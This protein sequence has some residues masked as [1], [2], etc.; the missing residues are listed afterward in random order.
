MV[1]M[2]EQMEQRTGQEEQIGEHAQG[3]A[4]VFVEQNVRS[5]E[6]ERGK[7]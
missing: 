4:P 5:N 6:S 3:M 2:G 7:G 1:S